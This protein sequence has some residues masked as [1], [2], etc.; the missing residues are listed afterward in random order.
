MYR[1]VCEHLIPGCTYEAEDPDR[2]KLL[3]LVAAHLREHHDLDHR[4]ERIA[5]ALNTDA[6]M[7][8]R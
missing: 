3:K 8:M 2:E 6:I 1:Y 7:Y 5:K 4:D